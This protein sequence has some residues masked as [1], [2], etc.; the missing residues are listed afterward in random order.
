[1]RIAKTQM[2]NLQFARSSEILESSSHV[3][4]D[5]PVSHPTAR[6]DSN[7][8]ARSSTEVEYWHRFT[9]FWAGEPCL[10]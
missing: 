6:N 10:S 1:M 4:G 2:M 3:A 9:K 8:R 5:A 7:L